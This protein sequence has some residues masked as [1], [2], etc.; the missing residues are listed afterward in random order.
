MT[1]IQLLFDLS[2]LLLIDGYI[3][4]NDNEK[5]ACEL[6]KCLFELEEVRDL[7]RKLVCDKDETVYEDAISYF[8]DIDKKCI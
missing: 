2:E 4:T 6:K 5:Y 7:L 8:E 3:I 1:N